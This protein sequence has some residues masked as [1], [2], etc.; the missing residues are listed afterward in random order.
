MHKGTVKLIEDRR[1]GD[2]KMPLGSVGTALLRL[3][4]AILLVEN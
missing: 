1:I 2:A 3:S 4:E